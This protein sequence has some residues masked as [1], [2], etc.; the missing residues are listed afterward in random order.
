MEGNTHLDGA[1]LCRQTRLI[2][3]Q[4]TDKVGACHCV[5]CRRWGGG[6]LLAIDCGTEVTLE[7]EEHIGLFDSSEWA[8]RGFC[9]NCG[10][11]LFYRLKGINQYIVP[12]GLFG[13]R[14]SHEFDHQVFID[15][16]P[17]YYDFANQTENMTGAEVFA[18]YA[19]TG[20]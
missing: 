18:K 12:A 11:H 17:A 19:P 10:T 4:P 5:M 3:A 8:E 6:P 16:K 7:G 15:H 14:D 20:E 9:K 1:C 2:A 13:D